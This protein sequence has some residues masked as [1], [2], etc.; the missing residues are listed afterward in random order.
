MRCAELALPSIL[1]GPAR[2]LELSDLAASAATKRVHAERRQG[3]ADPEAEAF[4]TQIVLE[5]AE[6][7]ADLLDELL[8][9][10]DDHP[11]VDLCLEGAHPGLTARAIERLGAERVHDGSL[12][13]DPFRV[14]RVQAGGELEVAGH[15]QPLEG[16]SVAAFWRSAAVRTARAESLNEELSQ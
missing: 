6:G 8:A 14:L 10:L 5:L 15:R 11:G 13:P 1:A 3:F 4:P 7:D 2:P 9:Q 16:S 12:A